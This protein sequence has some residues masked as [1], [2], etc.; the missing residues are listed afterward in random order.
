MFAHLSVRG[1][2]GKIGDRRIYQWRFSSGCELDLRA[3]SGLVF[4]LVTVHLCTPLH[5]GGVRRDIFVMPSEG[6]QDS[7]GMKIVM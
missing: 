1:P 3:L 5:T 6:Y 7:G 2:N 4:C